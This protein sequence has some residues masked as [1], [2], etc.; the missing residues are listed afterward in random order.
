MMPGQFPPQWSIN[1]AEIPKEQGWLWVFFSFNGRLERGRYIFGSLLLIGTIITLWLGGLYWMGKLNDDDIFQ[2]F[3]MLA[4]ISLIFVWPV[5]ALSMKRLRDMDEEPW[6][7]LLFVLLPLIPCVG[8]I[9]TLVMWFWMMIERGTIGPNKYG[10]QPQYPPHEASQASTYEVPQP[11][12][13][14]Q[15]RPKKLCPNCNSTCQY[16]KDYNDY[17]CWECKEYFW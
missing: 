12:D 17:Y 14:P 3:L 16:S 9:G 2:L 15:G 11:Q 4:G 10:P 1:W 13:Q 5:T 6:L 8:G 7:A